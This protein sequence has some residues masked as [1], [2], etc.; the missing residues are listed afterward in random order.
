MRAIGRGDGGA[1][2]EPNSLLA[3]VQQLNEE[4]VA[5][6]APEEHVH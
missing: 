6:A 3:E 1:A 4:K 5:V 2:A